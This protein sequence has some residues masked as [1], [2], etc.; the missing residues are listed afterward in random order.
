[1]SV[2]K[3]KLNIN[4][5][6][7]DGYVKLPIQLEST[8][9]GQFEDVTDKFIDV[10]VEKSI[11]PI[12]D[13]EKSRFTPIDAS[14]DSLNDVTISLDFLNSDKSAIISNTKYSDIGFI[15]SDIKY[16]K[17][18]FLNSFLRLSFYDNDV[19]TNQN[20]ISFVTIFSRIT[21]HEIV[22]LL[23]SEGNPNDGGGLPIPVTEFPVRFILT[24]PV[25]NRDGF[26]E[27]YYLYHYKSDNFDNK[28]YAD[29]QIN[30]VPKY[31]YMR[32][33]F[34][35]AATGTVTRMITTSEKLKINDL[36]NYL[37]VRYELIRTKNGFFYKLDET[38]NSATNITI[39]SSSATL[40]LY[41]IQ[42]E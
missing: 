41:E 9:L 37:H 17:A 36:M 16:R 13:Y 22:P 25:I 10:E 20:L 38:Y 11:N 35:N 7:N 1:M 23:D 4:N 31:L 18:R 12:I 26:S 14:Y 8:R 19:T 32:A 24:N 33:E 30:V 5:L 42:V 40:K 21:K 27:G 2:N 28:L 15:D 3:I 39:G 6:P 29:D 34:N